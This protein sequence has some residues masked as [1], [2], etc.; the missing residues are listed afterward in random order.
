MYTH[1]EITLWMVPTKSATRFCNQ[2]PNSVLAAFISGNDIP[3]GYSDSVGPRN[4]CKV[5][6]GRAAVEARC[7]N[8]KCCVA[9]DMESS[10]CGYLKAAAGPLKK[11]T[12]GFTSYSLASGKP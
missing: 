9:Y 1:I 7:N 5:C 6:G 2:Q 4:F 11:P 3:C 8:T 10:E 12:K